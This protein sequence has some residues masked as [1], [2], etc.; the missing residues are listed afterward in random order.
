[1]ENIQLLTKYEGHVESW[2]LDPGTTVGK[3]T[4][5]CRSMSPTYDQ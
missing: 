1:M 4:Q 3:Y 5:I 2:T